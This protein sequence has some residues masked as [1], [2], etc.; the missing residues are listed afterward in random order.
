[1]I[2]KKYQWDLSFIYKDEASFDADLE[3]IKAIAKEL[4]SYEGQLSDEEKLASFLRLEKEAELILNRLYSYAGGIADLDRRKVESGAREAKVE[5]ALQDL[6]RASSFADPEYLKLGKEKIESFL[7]SHPEFQEFDFSFVKLFDQA[8]HVL[9]G[10][11]EALLANFGPLSSV[12]GDL[13][14]NLSVSDYKAGKCTLSDGRE[15]SV[16]VSNWTTLM[17]TLDK[18]EDRQLVFETLY[19]YFD[20]RKNSYAAI[21]KA[22]LDAQL[23]SMRSRGYSSILES[24]LD[25]NKIPTSV[26][27]SLVKAAHEGSA[28]LKEYYEVRRKALGLTKHRSYDRFLALAKT[29]KKLDYEEARELFYKSIERFDSDFQG[30][31]HQATE[32][33]KVDVYPGEGKRSGAYSSGGGGILPHILLNFQGTLED[34]FTLAHEAGHSTHTLFSMEGQPIMKQNYT[35]FVAEIASTFN[36]H[37]LLDYLLK[38]GT[39]SKEDKIALLQKELD[40]IAA[41]FY[42]Q[43]LFAEYELEASRLEEKGEP[44]N[45]EVLSSIMVKLYK[46]YYGIDI[47]EEV[48]KPLVWCY[49]PHLYYTPFYVYQYATSFATSLELYRRVNEGVEG[50]FERYKG[51]LKSGG[52]AYP[53]EQVKAAGV[54]LTSEEPFLAVVRRMDYFVGELKKLLGQE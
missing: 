20:D 43:T 42:R 6:I 17:R 19:H 47:T 40:E 31:A 27:L 32:Y 4:P 14:S 37:N 5:S 21:Y 49:I 10:D 28:P 35:I 12:G 41:T 50:A 29:D 36:E 51:L 30:K 54:D 25:G 13:Y 52:S 23:A 45:Y 53:I 15:V 8:S 38:S 34:A 22:G 26:Y 3:R 11:K 18:A 48:Y 39:L 46:D 24:H 1:M 9:S 2:D 33:G 44:I 16:N 7:K